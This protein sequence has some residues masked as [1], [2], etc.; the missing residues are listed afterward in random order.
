MKDIF[1]RTD[2]KQFRE[3]LFEGGAIE[4]DFYGTYK[5]RLDR[6]SEDIIYALK[7]FTKGNENDDQFNEAMKE[8]T[9]AFITYRDVFTEIGMKIG[10]RLLYQLLYQDE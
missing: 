7:R 8:L 2:I 9:F 4:K 3:F 6:D 10:A 1:E 5:E